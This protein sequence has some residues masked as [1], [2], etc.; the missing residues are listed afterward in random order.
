M[1]QGGQAVH[2]A[3]H[4]LVRGKPDLPK[5]TIAL[6]TSNLSTRPYKLSRASGLL[7]DK[8]GSTGVAPNAWDKTSSE[9][10]SAIESSG[11]DKVLSHAL[12]GPQSWV[13]RTQSGGLGLTSSNWTTVDSPGGPDQGLDRYLAAVAGDVIRVTPQ[14]E[15]GNDAR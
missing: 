13:T 8:T 10:I 5:E 7:F 11:I 12:R 9:N 15:V 3:E 2:T 4:R 1:P 14:L 6:T